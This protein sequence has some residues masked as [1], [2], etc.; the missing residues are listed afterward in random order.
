MLLLVSTRRTGRLG[1]MKWAAVGALTYPLYLIHQYIGF[2][3]FHIAY[4]AVN[5]HIL[6]WGMILFMLAAA[7]LINVLVDQRWS[8]PLKNFLNRVLDRLAPTFTPGQKIL[9]PLS[10]SPAPPAPDGTNGSL[11]PLETR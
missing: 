8:T 2:M 10:E 4:P 9:S 1:K 7:H 3:I 11:Y 6:L 5:S